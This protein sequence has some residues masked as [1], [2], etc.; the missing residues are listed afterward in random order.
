MAVFDEAMLKPESQDMNAFVDG[1]NNICEAQQRVA[2]GYFFDGSIE[3]ACP[4]LKALLHI[5][6]HGEYQGMGVDDPA[7]QRMFTRNYLLQS[8]WYQERLQIKQARDKQ[9][10]LQH[11][12]YLQKQMQALDED[13][14]DQ[15]RYLAECIT[16]A[17]KLIDIVSSSD[18][19]QR[20]NGTLGADWICRTA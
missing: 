12:E 9:L 1:I 6:V 15:Q 8:D 11:R 19:L 16:E 18:Y 17:D 10:W 5:M 13:E 4:P 3:D 2:E 20:L 7:I 14:A